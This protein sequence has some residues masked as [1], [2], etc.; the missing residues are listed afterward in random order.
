MKDNFLRTPFFFGRN[1]RKLYGFFHASELDNEDSTAVLLCPA[2]GL[3]YRDTHQ[4][5]H[6]L[7]NRLA[8]AGHSVLRF[9]YYGTGDSSGEISEVRLDGLV[10][11]V[12][13]AIEELRDLS[14]T[15]AVTLIGI[16]MGNLIVSQIPTG[17]TDIDLTKLYLR[18]PESALSVRRKFPGF[19][20]VWARGFGFARKL[21]RQLK[22]LE[23]DRVGNLPG[24]EDVRSV[25]TQISKPSELCAKVSRA[26]NS[27]PG[28]ANRQKQEIP[29]RSNRSLAG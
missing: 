29:L 16:R 17:R 13:V 4:I 19:T 15:R 1:G 11:D 18:E 23:R 20:P 9:D 12:V 22:A 14:R 28:S 26:L 7:A 25:S 8:Q 6:L 3:D 5:L 2:L 21:V 27:Q 10:D 24:S